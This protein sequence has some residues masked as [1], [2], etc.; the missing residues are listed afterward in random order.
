MPNRFFPVF[1]GFFGGGEKG[2]A[3]LWGRKIVKK[4][5]AHL[6]QKI[7]REIPVYFT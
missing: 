4:P 6:G 2:F 7:K 5:C 1:S 3:N